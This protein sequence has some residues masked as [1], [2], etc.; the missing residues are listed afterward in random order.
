VISKLGILERLTFSPVVHAKRERSFLLQVVVQRIARKKS[1]ASTFNVGEVKDPIHRECKTGNK[2]KVNR[3]KRNNVLDQTHAPIVP[4]LVHTPKA[5]APF[6]MAHIVD[7]VSVFVHVPGTLV[8]S[9]DSKSWKWPIET[10]TC[11]CRP[12][13]QHGLDKKAVKDRR[14]YGCL[15]LLRYS[16]LSALAIYRI[17]RVAS[18]CSDS[19]DGGHRVP[20][21]SQGNNA[22]WVGR[23]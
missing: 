10:H 12:W 5:G 2:E 1:E 13:L 4:V 22:W 19:L 14:V 17:G 23:Q 20:C 11:R 9:H 6:T 7:T 3:G 21:T 8:T 18:R 15:A 16:F